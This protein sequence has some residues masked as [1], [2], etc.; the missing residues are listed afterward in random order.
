MGRISEKELNQ[1]ATKYSKSPAR[2]VA[3]VA[4]FQAAANLIEALMNKCD[5][6]EFIDEI[7]ELSL[8]GHYETKEVVADERFEQWYCKHGAGNDKELALEIWCAMD[9]ED[10]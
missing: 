3:F 5:T 9:E 1:F 4:G 10:K 2:Q 6:F 8:C 7:E